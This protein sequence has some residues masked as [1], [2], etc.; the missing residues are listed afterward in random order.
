MG[1]LGQTRMS[2]FVSPGATRRE[3]LLRSAV[4]ASGLIAPGCIRRRSGKLAVIP[5]TTAINYWE[6]MRV[7]AVTA[8]SHLG[9]RV[10][11]TAPQTETNFAQ[12]ASI[13][14]DVIRQRVDGIVLAPSHGSV[15]A[16][17]VRHARAENIPL[18]IVDSPVAVDRSEFLAYIGSDPERIGTLAAMRMGEI[19]DGKGEIAIL[20]VTPTLEASV[21]REQA[22]A[23]V[24]AAKFPGIRIVEVQYGLSDLAR[25]R[26]IVADILAGRPGLA[27][28]F[29][30]DYFAV[31]GA[32]AAIRDFKPRGVR[33]IG[34]AQEYDLL[35]YI[36]RGFVDSLVIQDPYSMGRS[37]VEI[38]GAALQGRYRGPTRIQTRVALATREN[39]AGST[40]IAEF[41]SKS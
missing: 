34:V 33:L 3:L 15:L 19:L 40:T 22:F 30:S 28:V 9:L 38:L 1:N 4:A 17:G 16:S 5:K 36:R 25:S 41:L 37:A 14:E 6:D 21:Q 26:A 2:E 11:W 12:Q 10:I 13:L 39:L 20:G 35:N 23:A 27:A 8:A 18:V 32:S 31:R 24:V 29:A 7:G